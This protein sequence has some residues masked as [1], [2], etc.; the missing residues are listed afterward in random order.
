MSLTDEQQQ[1]VD[2]MLSTNDGRIVA[3]NSVAGS[4]KTHTIKAVIE[5]IKPNNGFY[6]AF[7]KAIVED[8][9]NK[10]GNLLEVKTF[11]ALAYK[12]IRPKKKIEDLNY[13]TITEDIPYEDKH[14]IIT[15][16]D[17]FFRSNSVNIEEFTETKCSEDIQ[18]LVIKYANIMLE[19]KINPTFNYMLKCLHLMLYHKEI[20]IDY[21]L[22]LYD[23]VQDVT[24]VTLEIFKLLNSNKKL[25]VGDTYQNIY[26]FMN[27]VNAFEELDNLNLIKLTKSFRCND[28][29][30]SIV[31]DYGKEY[32][33]D[34]FRYK[35]NEQ[36][37]KEDTFKIVYISRSNAFLLERMHD[38]ISRGRG[39]T[40]TRTINEIFALPLALLNASKGN[41]VYDK[42]YK[43]LE[44]EY[45]N[46]Q[47]QRSYKGFFEYIIDVTNDDTLSNIIRMLMNFSQKG[48]NLYKLK[49]KVTDSITNP[50][51]IL[52]TAHAFKGLE[53]DNVYIEDDLNHQVKRIKEKLK[54]FRDYSD[55]PKVFLN[56]GEIENLNTYYVALSRARTNLINMEY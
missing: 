23:E 27:T 47:R 5:A 39:F 31:E 1:V 10:F 26:S 15:V 45:I 13:L 12:Y 34:T 50:N 30:A 44:K 37:V 48:I 42:Q 9:K 35:G 38:L 24:P 3:C 20:E 4:G 18:Q 25:I 49:E 2:T 22:V 32:L 19:G 21:D 17:D 29:I 6:S 16:L 54:D 40:L 36:I 28:H 46:Y 7:N 41:P 56:R 8:S 14:T 11:H 33:E 51:I 52:T 55:E 43:Y 53:C